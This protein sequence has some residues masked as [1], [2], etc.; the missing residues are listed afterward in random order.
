MNP[1]YLQGFPQCRDLA[2]RRA[3]GRIR[4]CLGRR[5]VGGTQGR[6][7]CRA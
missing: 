5:L 1:V 7:P 6:R 3:A 2:V 4:P